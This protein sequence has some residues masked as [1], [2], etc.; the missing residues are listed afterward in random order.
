MINEIRTRKF[1]IRLYIDNSTE[2]ELIHQLKELTP[3]IKHYALIKHDKEELEHYH[4]YLEYENAFTLNQ[5]KNHYKKYVRDEEHGINV[6]RVIPGTE[7]RII[8]YLIH[9]NDTDKYQYSKEEIKT[10]FHQDTLKRLLETEPQEYEYF[11]ANKIIEY[12]SQGTD[13][14]IQM[15]LRFGKQINAY[16]QLIKNILKEYSQYIEYE[17]LKEIN[18]NSCNY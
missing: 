17:K 15:Y 14:F 9:K 16:Q 6:E 10:N 18:E 4:I 3:K 13:T 11:N 1:F 2:E 12:I 5:V 7:E 8:Q